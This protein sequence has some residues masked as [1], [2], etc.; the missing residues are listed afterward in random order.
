MAAQRDAMSA[1]SILLLTDTRQYICL[2]VRD[3]VDLAV[4]CCALA[5]APIEF[6][7]RGRRADRDQE[8]T[9]PESSTSVES[10]S[11][12]DSVRAGYGRGWSRLT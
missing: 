2:V 3:T 12:A 8:E 5:V 4:V 9:E 6:V 7:E 11:S 10:Y 1:E